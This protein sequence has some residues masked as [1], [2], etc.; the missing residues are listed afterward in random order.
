M[1]VVTVQFSIHPQ[2]V[3][4]FMPEMVA[5][6]RASREREPGC[7]VFDV[8]QDPAQAGEVFLYEIYTDK[9]A[10]DEHLKSAHYLAFNQTVTPWVGNKV[11]KILTLV[12]R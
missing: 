2:H 11:V 9:V 1:F 6:A 4:A 7:K 8:C 5:N 12:D 3:A 10:F